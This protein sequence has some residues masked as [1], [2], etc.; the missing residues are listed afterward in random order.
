MRCELVGKA[1]I[2]SYKS[3]ILLSIVTTL[4][5]ALLIESA[6]TLLVLYEA[7]K[8]RKVSKQENKSVDSEKKG[9]MPEGRVDAWS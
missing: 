3:S 5:K 8:E 6:S 2:L 7:D 1:A 9:S 4:S